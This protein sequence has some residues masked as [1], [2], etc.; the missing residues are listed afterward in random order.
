M[1]YSYNAIINNSWNTLDRATSI[2]IDKI[3]KI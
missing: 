3:S 1:V 2:H